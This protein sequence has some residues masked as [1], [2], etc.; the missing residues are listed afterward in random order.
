MKNKLLKLLKSFPPAFAGIGRTVKRER[1]MRVHLCAVAFVVVTGIWQGLSAAH[2]AVEL[3][4]CGVV[5]GLE[6]LNSAVEALCDRV[7]RENDPFIRRAKDAASGAVLAAAVFSVIIWLVLLLWE[8]EYLLHFR[9]WFKY[10]GWIMAVIW[11]VCSW[12]IVFVPDDGRKERDGAEE[13]K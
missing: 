12:I 7:T 1:N 10:G 2:W 8:K 3:L 6:L 9:A 11:A 4:C 5:I 13:E